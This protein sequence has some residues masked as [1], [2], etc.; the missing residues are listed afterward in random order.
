MTR[1]L[2]L[3]FF[4]TLFLSSFADRC[5][6]VIQNGGQVG[7]HFELPVPADQPAVYLDIQAQQIIIEG[8]NVFVKTNGGQ[9]MAHWNS[10]PTSTMRFNRLEVRNN[11]LRGV[12]STENMLK[13]MTNVGY[14][15]VNGNICIQ[16][17]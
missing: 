2:L 14:R 9:L 7:T 8:N 3:Y 17:P 11:L 12:N 16:N 5:P 10:A 6:I 4:I 15:L 13:N 1:H